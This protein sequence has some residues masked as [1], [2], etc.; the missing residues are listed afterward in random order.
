G[1][2]LEKLLATASPSS[3]VASSTPEP[4]RGGRGHGPPDLACIGTS[5]YGLGAAT[6][7]SLRY[8]SH[9]SSPLIDILRRTIGEAFDTQLRDWVDRLAEQQAIG[10][11]A[12]AG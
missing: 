11:R 5:I 7:E 8:I 2:V 10:L 6:I 9:V 3:S 1:F 12:K 4:Q